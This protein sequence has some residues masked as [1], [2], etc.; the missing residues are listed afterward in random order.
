[1]ERLEILEILGNP[2]GISWQIAPVVGGGENARRKC[3]HTGKKEA[4]RAAI[5]IGNGTVMIL[6]MNA[7]WFPFTPES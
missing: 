6:W 7:A 4:Y 1:L 3:L 2:M 5:Q